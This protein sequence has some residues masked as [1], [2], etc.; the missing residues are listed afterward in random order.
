MDK[1]PTIHTG[2][3]CV[4]SRINL[5]VKRGD[6]GFGETTKFFQVQLNNNLSDIE[7][8]CSGIQVHEL[9]QTPAK[10]QEDDRSSY[11]VQSTMSVTA[12]LPDTT[13]SAPRKKKPEIAP[14]PLMGIVLIKRVNKVHRSSQSTKSVKSMT[15]VSFKNT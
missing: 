3:D 2:G 6:K 8:P 15:K 9:W 12:K 4:P 7:I 5:Q 14:K 1:L 10:H 13:L 11:L